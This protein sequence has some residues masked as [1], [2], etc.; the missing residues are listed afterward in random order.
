MPSLAE[1]PAHAA[2]GY[3]GCQKVACQ[4]SRLISVDVTEVSRR[5]SAALAR[6][7]IAHVL[8]RRG[9]FAG[10][11]RLQFSQRKLL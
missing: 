6:G 4:N 5:I 11:A 8:S 9:Y 2:L 1:R 10:F 3:V 7:N